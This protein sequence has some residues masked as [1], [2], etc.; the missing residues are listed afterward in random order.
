MM[1]N[2]DTLQKHEN[3]K[4]HKASGAMALSGT[5]VIE[6]F[7]PVA[8]SRRDASAPASQNPSAIA[9]RV[10][11]KLVENCLA[12]HLSSNSIPATKC[13]RLI[14]R[15]FI[16]VVQKLD[17]DHLPKPPSIR[18]RALPAGT[19]EF[20][21][22]LF[23]RLRGQP[24]T[25]VVDES[26]DRN[27]RGITNVIYHSMTD[28]VLVAT[29]DSDGPSTAQ[30]VREVVDTALM[31]TGLDR[32]LCICML[33]DNAAYM[34]SAARDLSFKNSA[35][36]LA[37]GLNLLAKC[38]VA[39]FPLLDE[40]VTKLNSFFKVGQPLARRIKAIDLLDVRLAAL[41]VST[42]RWNSWLIAVFEVDGCWKPLR[43]FC[44]SER[45]SA[46]TERIIQ[47]LGSAEVRAEAAIVC[48]LTGL[49][50]TLTKKAQGEDFSFED[51]ANLDSL[52]QRFEAFA[53][54]RLN[55][56]VEFAGIFARFKVSTAEKGRVSEKV[57]FVCTRIMKKWNRNMT[58]MVELLRR[59]NL[60]DPRQAQ[61]ELL[62]AE[63]FGTAVS[64]EVQGEWSQYVRLCGPNPQHDDP[65]IFWDGHRGRQFPRLRDVAV[66]LLAIPPSSAD[67]ERSFAVMRTIQ[68]PLR[69]SM[70][71]NYLKMELCLRYNR[72]YVEQ[73]IESRMDELTRD[74]ATQ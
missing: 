3:S 48:L 16:R 50:V 11:S 18:R 53:D 60:F 26:K 73:F 33:G 56:L 34:K 72:R 31:E 12:V 63:T 59:R 61:P 65:A 43:N 45:T 27:W 62:S 58:A 37:H 57:R 49:L 23:P 22:W 74:D 70:S 41:D 36:C 7:F 47:Q 14:N 5:P 9:D 1:F 44:Q 46:T 39:A 66:E 20:R 13:D 4:Q 6:S 52:K 17:I 2:A 29:F 28:C 30:S 71:V 69:T 67:V 25:L 35:T 55:P 54:G 68:T 21:E 51:L 19:N 38:F 24:F 10:D 40:L 32:K 64:S 15:T 8:A 42:T